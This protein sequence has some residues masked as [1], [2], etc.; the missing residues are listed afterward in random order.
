MG[1][2][3]GLLRVHDTSSSGRG[4]RLDGLGLGLDGEGVGVYQL[5]DACRIISSS[6]YDLT[7]KH[8]EYFGGDSTVTIAGEEEEEGPG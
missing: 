7:G 8:L 2:D 5:S 1:V 6:L 4:S 3:A